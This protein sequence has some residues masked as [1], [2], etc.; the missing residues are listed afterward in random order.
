MKGVR[1][2]LADDQWVMRRGLKAAFEGAGGFVVVGEADSHDLVARVRELHPDLVVAGRLRAAGGVVPAVREVLSV[3]PSTRMLLLGDL[4]D[5]APVLEAILGGASGYLSSDSPP[6]EILGA[7][8][9]VAQGDAYLAPAAA[10]LLFSRLAAERLPPGPPAAAAPET[11]TR[12]EQQV[13]QLLVRNHRNREIAR[14]LH[15]SEATVKTHVSSVLRKL[16]VGDRSG[17]ILYGARQGLLAPDHLAA[18]RS[19]GGE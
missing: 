17:V 4:G 12:R 1:L 7:A 13:F 5:E 19:R 18:G 14:L 16:G 10:R 3:L 2:L 6:H 11:L 8:R 15:I 9:V